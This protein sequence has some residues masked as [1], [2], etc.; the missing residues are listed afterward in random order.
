VW[1]KTC[2][3]TKKIPMSIARAISFRRF[4]LVIQRFLKEHETEI[5]AGVYDLALFRA[6]D[7][8]RVRPHKADK[9]LR[10]APKRTVLQGRAS[11]AWEVTRAV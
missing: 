4:L 3:Q 2:A 8:V 5:S 9:D 6:I 1:P 7:Q 10:N 11:Q